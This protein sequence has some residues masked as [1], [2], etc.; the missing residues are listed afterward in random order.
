VGSFRREPAGRAEIVREDPRTRVTRVVAAGRT[1]IR[2]ELRGPDS[3]RRLHHQLEMLQRLRGVPGV[4]QLAEETLPGALALADAGDRSLAAA[5][6]PLAVQD[7][8]VLGLGLARAVAGMHRRGVMHRN[9]CPANI[10]VGDDGAPCLVDFGL[11]TGMAEIRPDFTPPGE[12]VGTLAYLAPE[13]T[14]RT[15]RAVDER[16]DLYAVGATPRTV[17]PAATFG[18][19]RGM[20][21]CGWCRPRGWWAAMSRS[22][23]WRRRSTTRWRAG[24][25]GCWLPGRPGWAR[26]R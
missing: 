25:A 12:I 14:G 7:L 23:R 6:T 15:G 8:V 1:V 20:C 3:D 9:I 13:Q 17:Q 5:A 19:A 26:P 11:A 16:A 24:A 4:A 2:K 10:V 22:R 21:R 18:W